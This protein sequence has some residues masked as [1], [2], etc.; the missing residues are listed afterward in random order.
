M[1]KRKP[2]KGVCGHCGRAVPFDER[3]QYAP[4]GQLMK[5]RC[6]EHR[7]KWGWNLEQKES[8]GNP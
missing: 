8:P 6:D 4:D 7:E 3:H 1:K 2:Q 5:V